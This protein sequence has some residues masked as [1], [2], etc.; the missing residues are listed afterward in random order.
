[1]GII[2]PAIIPTSLADLQEKLQVL[3]GVTTDVQVDIVDGVYAQPASWPYRDDPAEPA[4]M[5]GEDAFLPGVGQF[6]LEID[7]MS[8]DPESSAGTWI[9]LGANRLT[10][11]AAST[12]YLSRFLENMRTVMGHDKDF[13]PGLL[14]LGLALSSETDASLV[15]PYLDRIDYVQFMGIR[16]IGHQ[17]E[18]FDASVLPRIAAFRKKHPGMEV[19][20]DGGVT[21]QNAGALLDAGVSRLVAGSA[22][23]KSP[24]P[25]GAYHA[26]AALTERHGLYG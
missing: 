21:L 23:W 5:L 14:S 9:G 16:T 8:A 20:V 25:V 1:M 4:R 6:A 10:V 11:H 26:L 17:G 7:L 13:I 3:E 24:D 12:R 2:V 19:T 22:I 15:E 18:P